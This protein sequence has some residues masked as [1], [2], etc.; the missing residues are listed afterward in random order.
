MTLAR[1]WEERAGFLKGQYAPKHNHR[2]GGNRFGFHVIHKLHSNTCS[3]NEFY[4]LKKKTR[5]Y[6]YICKKNKIK[7]LLYIKTIY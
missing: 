2:A 3:S 7:V 4:F 5:S 6:I 1:K